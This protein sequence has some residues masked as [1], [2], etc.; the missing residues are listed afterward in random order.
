[1]HRFN[2]EGPDG[3]TNREGAGRPCLLNNRQMRERAR[4]VETGPDREST[5]VVRWRRIDPV[6]II[7]Q[8]FGVAC[9]QSVVSND[10]VEMILLNRA[11]PTSRGV[12]GTRPGTV[13]CRDSQVIE[14]FKKTLPTRWQRMEPV[15]PQKRL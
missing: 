2:E 9:W 1:M 10:L 8:R 5:G 3:L 13:R 6:R 4:I 15:F 12:R 14:A 7:D 11:F